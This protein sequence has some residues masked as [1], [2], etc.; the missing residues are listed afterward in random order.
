MRGLFFDFISMAVK[1]NY[2]A[3][4]FIQRRLLSSSRQQYSEFYKVWEGSIQMILL[5]CWKLDEETVPDRAVGKLRLPSEFRWVHLDAPILLKQRQ[6]HSYGSFKLREECHELHALFRH[7][8]SWLWPE[9]LITIR[10][11]KVK[12]IVTSQITLLAIRLDNS[13]M[14]Y[15]I[16]EGIS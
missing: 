6:D 1:R 3:A 13:G 14:W 11:S 15:L 4:L 10:G 8:K 7:L 16:L 5:S 9:E 2:C 12:E